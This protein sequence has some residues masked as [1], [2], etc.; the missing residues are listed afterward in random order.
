MGKIKDMGINLYDLEEMTDE[1]LELEINHILDSGANSIRL[2]T[3]CKRYANQ[4]TSELQVRILDYRKYLFPS[5]VGLYDEHFGIIAE[6]QG[7]TRK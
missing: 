4:Q 7:T 2:S 5:E 3:L 6:T 1:Q